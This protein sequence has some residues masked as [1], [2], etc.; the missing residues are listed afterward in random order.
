MEEEPE[1]VEIAASLPRRHLPQPLDRRYHCPNGSD[2]G[3]PGACRRARRG[4]RTAWGNGPKVIPAPRPR[5]THPE[6]R[7]CR[8]AGFHHWI[9]GFQASADAIANQQRNSL[10]GTH[11]DAK[12]LCAHFCDLRFEVSYIS[13]RTPQRKMTIHSATQ[14]GLLAES[15][16]KVTLKTVS[17]PAGLC[18]A[19]TTRTVPRTFD[20]TGTGAGNRT[21]FSP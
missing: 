11:T 2:R 5:P 1:S 10:P 6:R 4:R 14:T 8:G 21:L 12:P 20:P 7:S 9:E 16:S 13:S 19:D 18:C 15:D 17:T 3:E